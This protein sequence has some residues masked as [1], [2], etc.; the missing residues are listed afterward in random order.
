MVTA[1]SRHRTS[2]DIF[3]WVYCSFSFQQNKIVCQVPALL[4]GHLRHLWVTIWIIAGW[5]QR[6]IA[7]RLLVVSDALTTGKEG[8]KFDGDVIARLRSIESKL[9]ALATTEPERA[10]PEPEAPAETAPVTGVTAIREALAT[11]RAALSI[12]ESNL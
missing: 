2:V 3:K 4:N 11:A 5:H 6:N 12:I 10:E 7:D 1:N 9:D 8:V